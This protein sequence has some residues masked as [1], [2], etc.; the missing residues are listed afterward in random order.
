MKV[1]LLDNVKG[2]GRVGDVKEV[3]DGYARNFLLPRKLGKPATEGIVRAAATL[4]AQKLEAHTLEQSQAEA[5]AARIKGSTITVHGKANEKGT[6]FSAIAT[7]EIA[8]LISELAHAHI[9]PTAIESHE[10]LK[11]LGTH[12]V[13]VRLSEHLV[14]EVNVDIQSK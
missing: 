4:K 1:V 5:L 11:H 2:I 7:S 12:T 6:L 9:D 8:R 3:N 10:H 14:T 13:K